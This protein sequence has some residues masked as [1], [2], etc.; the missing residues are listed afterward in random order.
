MTDSEIEEL[1][2]RELYAVAPDLEG[3]DIEPDETFRDQFEIDSMDTLNFI[4]GL[5]KATGLEVPEADYPKLETFAGCK[6]YISQR[7]HGST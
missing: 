1:V 5:S 7:L 3:L 4:I 2:R 6:N